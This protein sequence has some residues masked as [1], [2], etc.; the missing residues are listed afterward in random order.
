MALSLASVLDSAEAAQMPDISRLNYLRPR[1]LARWAHV[2]GALAAAAM[3][4][5]ATSTFAKDAADDTA[6]AAQ[7]KEGAC[8]GV[9]PA[10]DVVSAMAR[11]VYD[12]YRSGSLSSPQEQ[13]NYTNKYLALLA[14]D[15]NNI[16]DNAIERA[17][18][19]EALF[20][21]FRAVEAR[22]H[23]SGLMERDDL[24]GRLAW[25]RMMQ[26]A[27]TPEDGGE[28]MNAMLVKYREKFSQT[29]F[30]IAGSAQQ[31]R[32][33]ASMYMNAGKTEQAL[34]LIMKELASLPTDAPY[35]GY[36]LAEAF[37]P[38]FEQEGRTEELKTLL[39][40][41]LKRLQAA[42]RRMEKHEP[43]ASKDP[44]LTDAAPRWYWVWQGV[45]EGETFHAARIR[46]MITL[47]GKLK[48]LVD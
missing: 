20:L 22:R 5:V 9:M 28:K 37:Y 25:Q 27:F 46:Q 4:M 29:P 33:L 3:G 31:V 40:N 1:N 23:F 6:P 12:L 45:E 11:E 32:N 36:R 48:T 47:E 7:L 35:N 19:G 13:T 17:A 38:A 16:P 15:I 2:R 8:A 44:V 21:N 18:L 26:M 43:I 39:S 10:T 24:I 42:R 14:P 30:D 34:D 41:K